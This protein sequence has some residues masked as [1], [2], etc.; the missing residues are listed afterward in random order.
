[1]IT[2]WDDAYSNSVYIEH[3]E[4]YPKLWKELAA[5]FRTEARAELDIPYGAG[6]RERFDLF[7]PTG[8]PI[9]L[10]FCCSSGCWR[11]CYR[12]WKYPLKSPS[13]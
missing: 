12:I 1:M 10:F 8:T 3:A 9:W 2:D 11:K 7:Y 13:Q 5:Q 6:E 4:N